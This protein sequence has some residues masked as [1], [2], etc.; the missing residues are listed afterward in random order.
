MKS[1]IN[2]YNNFRQKLSQKLNNVDL[3]R[4]Y[5]FFALIT[6]FIMMI[7]FVRVYTAPFIEVEI[8]NVGNNAFRITTEGSEKDVTYNNV[9]FVVVEPSTYY[10]RQPDTYYHNNNNNYKQQTNPKELKSYLQLNTLYIEV[11]LCTIQH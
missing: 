7:P 4:F 11:K 5:L 9:R 1:I 6:V 8:K 10:H 3:R 2:K